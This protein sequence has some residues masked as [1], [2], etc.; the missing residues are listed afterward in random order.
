MSSFLKENI[1]E[2][3]S[4]FSLVESVTKTDQPV[5]SSNNE[6]QQTIAK[7]KTVLRKKASE[8]NTPSIA[9]A[10][11]GKHI[12]AKKPEAENTKEIRQ[13]KSIEDKRFTKEELFSIWPN[14]VEKFKEQSHVYNTLLNKPELS[15]NN[16]V[17]ISVENSVQQ[18]KVR[19]I[20]PEIIGII[21]ENLN[22]ST[23]LMFAILSYANLL[24]SF[25]VLTQRD[26][27]AH[28]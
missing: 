12:E 10:L 16:V 11:S 22:V 15:E 1:F 14:F 7:P 9:Q 8:L 3:D 6:S 27:F 28:G 5:K 25:V 24:I 17:V 2:L 13:D 20:K 18:D 23:T 19:L 4:I 26:V 21:G